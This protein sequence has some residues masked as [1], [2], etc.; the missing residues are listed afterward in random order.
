M[1]QDR[2]IGVD[3]GGT[4]FRIGM[5]SQSKELI[6]FER[7]S[8]AV[9]AGGNAVENLAKQIKLYIAGRRESDKVRAVSIG[10]PSIVS[11]DKTT[12]YNTP[13]IPGLDQ[14]NLKAPLEKALG[15]PVFIDRDVNFLLQ[16]DMEQ[17][18]LDPSQTILGFYIGTGFGNAIYL[19]GAFYSGRNGVAGELGHVPLYGVDDLC[20]CGNRGCVETRSSGRYLVHLLGTHFPDTEIDEVFVRHGEDPLILRYVQ[21]LAL[22]IAMEINILDPDVSVIAG[23]VT[24]MAGFPRELLAAAVKQHARKPYPE[25]NLRLL[26]TEH[27]Q[28]SGVLGGASFAFKQLMSE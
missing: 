13:N 20:T 1:L 4:N 26:F 15:V 3:I 27:T 2:V 8:S 17:L 11:K 28:Q 7:K 21:D 22:P 5:V 19:N 16:N 10:F 23:G 18:G 6:D 24:A 14:I 12:L 25:E 9:L